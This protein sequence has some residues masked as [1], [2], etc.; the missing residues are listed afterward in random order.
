MNVQNRP[1]VVIAGASG[2]VGLAL[3]AHLSKRFRVVA[4][5]RSLAHADPGLTT[6]GVE[7]RQC[8]LFSLLETEEALAG[9]DFAIY[10]V[11]SML[12][13][14]RLTQAT[15]FDLDLILADNFA[16]AARLHRIKQIVYLG[17]L[18]PPVAKLSRH[19]ASRLEVEQALGSGTT[20]VTALRAGLVVGAGGSSLRILINLVHHLPLM[21][22][23]PWVKSRMQPVAIQDVLRAVERVLGDPA[24]F[25]NHYDIGGPDVMNYRELLQKTAR[26]LGR[27]TRMV[28]LPF[29]ST[30]FSKFW[31]A[32]ITGASPALVGPLVDSL[33]H[34]M[35]ARPNPLLAYLNAGAVPFDV[36]LQQSVD[37]ERRFIRP[38][39]AVQR[40]QDVEAMRAAK[41]VRSVQ[42]LPL[43]AEISA[44]WVAEEYYRWLPRYVWPFLRCQVDAS[45]RCRF[46]FVSARVLLLELTYSP[47]RSTDDR[48]LFYITGGLLAR[49]QDNKKGRLEFR[50]M[51]NR[52]CV[53][54][55]I[56]DFAPTLPWYVYNLTQAVAHLIVMRGFGRHLARQAAAAAA[57]KLTPVG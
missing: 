11:H 1:T 50:E 12:P 14:S 7:W 30:W 46:Y 51:L 49:T 41:R 26:L 38:R 24:Y 4:L 6:A 44:R 17:G 13:S 5:T 39:L 57:V 43:P 8:D 53:L 21:M 55:A 47:A 42:R 3:C 56:H 35:L 2:F 18:I 33:K 40:S 19:L 10:L 52:T 54:A 27:R 34:D 32:W 37:A 16:R 25:N 23:P 22:L 15:F 45:G 36:A 31:V 28:G 20:A 29:F 48:V 9:A